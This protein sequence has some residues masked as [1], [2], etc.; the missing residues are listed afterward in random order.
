MAS[1][2]LKA[3]LESGIGE[4]AMRERDKRRKRFEYLRVVVVVDGQAQP[5]PLIIKKDDQIDLLD[6]KCFPKD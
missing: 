1:R 5:N 4:G 2:Q 6:K 3:R